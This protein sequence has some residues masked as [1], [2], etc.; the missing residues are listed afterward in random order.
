MI[1]ISPRRDQYIAHRLSQL[2]LQCEP[3]SFY[4]PSQKKLDRA[5]GIILLGGADVNP[6]IYFQEPNGA[7]GW[8]NDR[9]K[10][11]LQLLEFAQHYKLPVLGICRG[12]QIF[13]V[14]FGGTLIQHMEHSGGKHLVDVYGTGGKIFGETPLI[15]N[16]YHHQAVD[17]V[18]RGLE[19]IGVHQRD[20]IIEATHHPKLRWAAVQWHP[21]ME[22]F[23]HTPTMDRLLQYVFGDRG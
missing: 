21:E 11:E 14:Y 12:S 2:G 17:K 19:V 8:N 20:G 16:T 18:G 6:S 10:F 13:N 5:T 22:T 9:D 15:T 23:D 4:N 7:E 1:L 3:I